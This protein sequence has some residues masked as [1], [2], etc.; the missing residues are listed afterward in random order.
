MASDQ[1]RETTQS[2]DQGSN[3]SGTL[4]GMTDKLSSVVSGGQGTGGDQSYLN[5]G[6]SPEYGPCNY[7]TR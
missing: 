3:N 1:Q 2:T 5:K 6:N 4:G 7:A